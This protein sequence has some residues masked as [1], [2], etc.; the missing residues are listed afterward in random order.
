MAVGACTFKYLSDKPKKVPAHP[1]ARPVGLDEIG[2]ELPLAAVVAAPAR[3][4]A[5]RSLEL[6]LELSA[7]QSARHAA[8][9][10]IGD[11]EERLRL[12]IQMSTEA[13]KPH[14]I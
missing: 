12:A 7:I 3:S 8:H 1:T 2:C 6:A 14:D 4:S 5:D 10:Q 13:S 9:M 11:D